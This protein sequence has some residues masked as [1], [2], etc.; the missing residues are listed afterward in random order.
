[1]VEL[2]ADAALADLLRE[3]KEERAVLVRDRVTGAPVGVLTR[4]DLVGFLS[5]QGGAH[6][7]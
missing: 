3:L 6:A 2:P 4:A 1:M 5:E 7:V